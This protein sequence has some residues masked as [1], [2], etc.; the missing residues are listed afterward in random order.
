MRALISG[1]NGQD[2]S[3]LAE[4]L[5]AL[6]YRVFGLVR[7]NSITEH[8][9]TRIEHIADQVETLYGDVLDGG[10]LDAAISRA[11]P[12]E[13]YNLAAQSHVRIS[14]DIPQYTLQSNAVGALNMLES[15]R[16]FAP[17]ARFY[18]AS[19]SEMFGNSVDA[20]GMQRETTPMAPVSPY[21]CAKLCAY[22]ATRY[23]RTGYRMFCANGILFNHESPRRASNFVTH[24]IVKSA[25][26]ISRKK[27]ATVELGNLDARRDWGHSH[28]YVRAMRMILA[29][30]SPDDF[31]VATGRTHSVRELC[32][33]VFRKVGLDYRNHVI[34]NPRL[35]RPSEVDHLCGDAGKA[36]RVLGWSPTHN[37]ES[38]V[39]EMIDACERS[40]ADRG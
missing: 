35:L 14:F 32:E 30:D 5:L 40:L 33:V 18:Q 1:V 2:G 10:S 26:L 38:I 29:H 15:M 39:D 21:G 9:R 4:H 36:R 3:Y 25:V 24:K 19:S 27:A 11:R 22:H 6:G 8:Q 20:D 13:I 34:Q 17:N 16:R 23:Y 12:D 31:V 7:R 28:D 37:L